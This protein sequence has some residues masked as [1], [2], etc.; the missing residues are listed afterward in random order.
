MLY[1]FHVLLFHIREWGGRDNVFT[2]KDYLSFGR[3]WVRTLNDMLWGFFHDKEEQHLIRSTYYMGW[4][5]SLSTVGTYDNWVLQCVFIEDAL[6]MHLKNW[7]VPSSIVVRESMRLV[8]EFILRLGTTQPSNICT[9]F[10]LILTY[11]SQE[12]DNGGVFCKKQEGRWIDEKVY[13]DSP[14]WRPS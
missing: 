6:P 5:A 14:K 3:E 9:P 11:I 8:Q 13:E 2:D 12:I 10:C 4:S 7:Q 1:F